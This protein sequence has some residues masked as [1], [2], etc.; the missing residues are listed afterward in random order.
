MST[1]CPSVNNNNTEGP[2]LSISHSFASSALSLRYFLTLLVFST[3][4]LSKHIIVVI[5]PIMMIARSQKFLKLAQNFTPGTA[6]KDMDTGTTK[7]TTHWL[8]IIVGTEWMT[9]YLMLDKKSQE[10]IDEAMQALT[11]VPGL[12]KE[13]VGATARTLIEKYS[14]RT[15]CRKR[16]MSTKV[17]K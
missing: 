6:I 14:K 1:S 13:N 5:K 4:L 8:N 9:T 15:R 3:R 2:F 11:I 16:Q 17:E 12:S 10:D 7:T